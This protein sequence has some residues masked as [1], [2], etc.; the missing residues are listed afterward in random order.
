MNRVESKRAS[1]QVWAETERCL[2]HLYT[3]GEELDVKRLF[4]HPDVWEFLGGIRE[5]ESIREITYEMSHEDR[6]SFYWTVREKRTDEFIGLVSLDS[7]H[8]GNESEVSYQFLPNWWGRGYAQEVV[9][10]LVRYALFELK[11]PKVLAETQTAN[12]ASCRLLERI[13]MERERTIVRFGA[14]PA[15]YSISSE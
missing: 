6:D 3:E 8:D 15:V 11:L 1:R 7:H 2:I 14:E 12:R 4:V 5:E 13:G 10:F 9:G